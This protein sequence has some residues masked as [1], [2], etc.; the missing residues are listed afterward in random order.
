MPADER[1]L[2]PTENPAQAPWGWS[3]LFRMRLFRPGTQVRYQGRWEKVSHVSLNHYDMT[4][5]LQGK[6]DP[7]AAL[8]L[9][10]EP[11]IFTTTRIPEPR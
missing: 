5:Y 7:V 9:E 8:E 6:A 11:T 10:L 4:V 1:P 3:K 2:L